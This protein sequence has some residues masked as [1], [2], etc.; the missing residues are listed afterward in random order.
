[1]PT[2]EELEKTMH[3]TDKHWILPE[4]IQAS[5]NV[6]LIG[7]PHVTK[8]ISA[9]IAIAATTFTKFLGTIDPLFSARTLYLT[10]DVFVT[11]TNLRKLLSGRGIK[12]SPEDLQIVHIPGDITES[13]YEPINKQIQDHRIKLI[14]I[15]VNDVFY[16]QNLWLDTSQGVTTVIATNQPEN[17]NMWPP[18]KARVLLHTTWD[19]IQQT[20]SISTTNQ[21]DTITTAR[22]IITKSSIT[23]ERI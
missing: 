1:M 4:T 3:P 9:E 13:F 16:V 6:L 5:S 17:W 18:R 15:N 21:K 7:T 22:M 14:I 10:D 23:F 19:M 11:V 20:M 8:L 12:D 2:L